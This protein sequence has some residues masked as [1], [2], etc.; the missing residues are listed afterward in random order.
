MPVFPS[1]KTPD[2]T[3]ER[4]Q[5]QAQIDHDVVDRSPSEKHQLR[6]L[7]GHRVAISGRH[8]ITMD[9]THSRTQPRCRFD[10]VIIINRTDSVPTVS[11]A[12]DIFQDNA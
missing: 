7:K 9:I 3:F 11:L 12:E 2:P 8:Q 4:P 6:F 1:S 5:L 10:P